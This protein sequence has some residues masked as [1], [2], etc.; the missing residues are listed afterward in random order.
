MGKLCVGI[1]VFCLLVSSSAMANQANSWK[2]AYQFP[3]LTDD[4]AVCENLALVQ[5]E[6][7]AH[8]QGIP[9]A[10]W[11]QVKKSMFTDIRAKDV[12]L[13]LVQ[14]PSVLIGLNLRQ[15][16]NQ[17]CSNPVL[18]CDAEGQGTCSEISRVAHNQ[19]LQPLLVDEQTLI[20]R[21]DNFTGDDL[22]AGPPDFVVSHDKG[23]SWTRI[24][25]PVPCTDLRKWC[26]LVP[27]TASRYFLMSTQFSYDAT[28]I[29]IHVTTDAGKSWTLLTEKW[30]GIHDVTAVS[31][32]GDTFVGL[33]KEPGEFVTLSRLTPSVNEIVELKTNISTQAWSPLDDG[34]VLDFEGGYLV[35][36][37]A[38]NSAVPPN[39]FGIVFVPAPGN[40]APARLI[41]ETHLNGGGIG[42]FQASEGIIAI[43][44]WGPP[45]IGKAFTEQIHYSLD[46]GRTWKI[47]AVP[48]ELL[49]SA[50]LLAH[51]KVWLFASDAVK[52]KDLA[53]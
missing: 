1:A 38:A 36:L 26:R 23:K 10:V 52:S 21:R 31:V 33:L 14:G 15:L 42:D 18:T 35:R 28:D 30:Q 16:G 37:N 20:A 19:V 43:R 44:T 9:P 29:A 47:A 53:E 34:K 46:E 4:Y 17:L 11:A 49:G 39:H 5:M 51:R 13:P 2:H 27:Q 25:T 45:L 41:W 7:L 22:N 32:V 40:P 8:A 50:M 12:V 3:H 6:K 48:V 24:D